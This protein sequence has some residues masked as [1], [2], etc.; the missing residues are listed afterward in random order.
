MAGRVGSRGRPGRLPRPVRALRF[1]TAKDLLDAGHSVT[2]TAPRSGY[3]SA[4]TL[5]RTFVSHLG[6]SP[7]A[8]QRRFRS[9]IRP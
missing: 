1:D 4:E 5:R 3:R 6:V 7:R 9:A 8:Y 2:D